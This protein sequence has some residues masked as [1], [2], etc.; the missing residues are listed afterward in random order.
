MDNRIRN[1][2]ADSAGAWIDKEGQ[3]RDFLST[4]VY[5]NENEQ[6][7]VFNYAYLCHE[8]LAYDYENRDALV[9]FY[10]VNASD[11]GNIFSLTYLLS[12]Y[13]DIPV[14]LGWIKIFYSVK[15]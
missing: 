12:Q 1:D 10:L 9:H 2:G 5:P 3:T 7:K 6:E 13:F 4:L 15:S 11:M 8:K 14:D